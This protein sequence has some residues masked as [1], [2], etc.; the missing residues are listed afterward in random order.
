VL[1]G[2]PALEI[3]AG[4]GRAENNGDAGAAATFNI[5]LPFGVEIGPGGALYITEIQNH[6][7]LRL[8]FKTSRISTVAGTGSRGYSGDGGPATRA[9]MNEPYEVRFDSLGNMYVVEM[10]NHIVRR[11]DGKRGVISTIA[12]S[13]SAGY[14]GDGGAA[15]EAR[16]NQP[17]S[18]ALDR[19]DNLY[20]ADINNHRI[21]RVDAK[22]GVIETIAGDG[23]RALP[24]DGQAA[25]G[26]PIF[27]PRA[28]FMQRGTLWIALREG[29]SVWRMDVA[30]GILR[31]VAGTGQRGN[32]GDGGLAP[33]ATFNGPKGIAVAP[34]GT[35]YIVDS[36]N[37]AVREIEPKAGRIRS[38]GAGQFN[39]AHG[40]CVAPNGD[41]FVGDSANHRVCR[42]R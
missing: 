3:V 17:H 29:Q 7:V 23:K 28:L 19:D 22:T 42:V 34:N 6:R 14:S 8:D 12:G 38:I 18:I 41:V 30:D 37:N 40:I 1:A 33:A 9:Q 16:L 5:G 24:V 10:K 15:T 31:Q 27:G 20:I 36:D 32:S 39:Q 2:N 11:I 13:G 4:T 25:R 26:K 21:R 35:I